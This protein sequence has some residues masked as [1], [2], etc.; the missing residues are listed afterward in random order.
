MTVA[1]FAYLINRLRVHSAVIERH[2]CVTLARQI[3]LVF[4]I[5][6][7]GYACFW[8]AWQWSAPHL[9]GQIG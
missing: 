2:Q 1:A 9:T 4:V 8:A 5:E 6:V 3:A 7:I